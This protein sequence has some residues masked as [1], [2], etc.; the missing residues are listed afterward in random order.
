M[1]NFTI[2]IFVVSFCVEKKIADEEGTVS[3]TGIIG[4]TWDE[5][6]FSQL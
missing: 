6:S 3:I 4:R 1:Q 5:T 2:T